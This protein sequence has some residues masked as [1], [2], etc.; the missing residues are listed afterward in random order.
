VV[1]SVGV[2]HVEQGL[3]IVAD[4]DAA[5]GRGLELGVGGNLAEPGNIGGL[6]GV[7]ERQLVNGSL[8]R[9]ARS[10]NLTHGAARDENV[11]LVHS[12]ALGADL[13]GVAD[14]GGVPGQ[15]TKAVLGAPLLGDLEDG[16]LGR[17]TGVGLRGGRVRDRG[18][19]VAVAGLEEAA[20]VVGGSS[21]SGG[22]GGSRDVA[23]RH[24]DSD[25]VEDIDDLDG[26]LLQ[27]SGGSANGHHG[28]ED[29][30][31]VHVDLIFDR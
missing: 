27:G 24:G 30:R 10:D 16:V 13:V 5:V 21:R 19:R 12:M 23:G 26:A 14:H 1:A 20:A 18:R 11:V 8:E 29:Q 4:G 28:T 3:D 31:S 9:L 25:G 15:L 22:R 7:G 17:V 2:L 6:E